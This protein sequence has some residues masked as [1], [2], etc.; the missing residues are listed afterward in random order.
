MKRLVL[1]RGKLGCV[2]M[3]AFCRLALSVAKPNDCDQSN[4][5]LRLWLSTN[6]QNQLAQPT[7][8][9]HSCYGN[10]GNKCEKLWENS[11]NNQPVSIII[12]TQNTGDNK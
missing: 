6:L 7:R 12:P 3:L 1:E 10:G 4:V 9:S 8:A 5:G 11:P 2:R